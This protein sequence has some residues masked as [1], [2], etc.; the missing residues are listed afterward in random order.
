M[1]LSVCADCVGW[2]LHAYVG[3]EDDGCYHSQDGEDD[4]ADDKSG[5]FR[6]RYVIISSWSMVVDKC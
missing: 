1:L 6:H 2:A 3:V 5:L 4:S